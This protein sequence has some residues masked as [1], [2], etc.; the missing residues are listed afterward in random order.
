MSLGGQSPQGDG[1]DGVRPSTPVLGWRDGAI[2]D[3]S[4]LSPIAPTLM[5]TS[6]VE[7]VFIFREE[8]LLVPEHPRS[9]TEGVAPTIDHCL[10]RSGLFGYTVNAL[11]NRAP[12]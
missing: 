11:G 6:I 9:G 5:A 8:R 4:R 10:H 7:V 1:P 2:E 12:K 3:R